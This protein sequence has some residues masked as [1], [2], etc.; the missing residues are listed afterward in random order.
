MN[1]KRRYPV[2]DFAVHDTTNRWSSSRRAPGELFTPDAELVTSE[3]PRVDRV[4]DVVLVEP[5]RRPG[6]LRRFLV[7]LLYLA[8]AVSALY[9]AA[10]MADEDTV[11]NWTWTAL[12]VVVLGALTGGLRGRAR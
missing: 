2:Q 7:V 6:R 5:Q 1:P 10:L 11:G 3:M 4:R 8:A 12:A 9:L